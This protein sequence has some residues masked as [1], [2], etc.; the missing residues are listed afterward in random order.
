MMGLA[1]TVLLVGVAGQRIG[2]RKEKRKR[3]RKE[4]SNL[5]WNRLFEEDE[6]TNRMKMTVPTNG[7]KPKTP[8]QN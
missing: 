8:L 5:I 2:N 7:S 4:E 6:Q 1:G 3:T